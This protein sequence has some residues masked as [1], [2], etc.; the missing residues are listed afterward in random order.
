MFKYLKQIP[1]INNVM[2]VDI[3]V[4]TL[5]KNQSKVVPTNYDFLTTNERK[6]VLI[7]D[8]YDGSIA[9]LDDRMLGVDAIVCIEL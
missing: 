4:E 6:E 9:D 5:E 2:L 7:V 3:D 8:I 1:G